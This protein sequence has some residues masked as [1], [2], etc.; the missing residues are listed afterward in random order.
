MASYRALVEWA[1]AAG[2]DV[3]VE[4]ITFPTGDTARI[5]FKTFSARWRVFAGDVRTWR[6]VSTGAA[7]L[8]VVTEHP[9][10]STLQEPWAELRLCGRAGEIIPLLASLAAEH[11]AWSK[12]AYS[13][14]DFMNPSL[15]VRDLLEGGHGVLATGPRALVDRLRA[16]LA[17]FEVPSMVAPPLPLEPRRGGLLLLA[18][19]KSWVVASDLRAEPVGPKDK[20]PFD[21]ATSDD[22]VAMLGALH[23]RGRLPELAQNLAVKLSFFP[24]MAEA[25]ER[26]ENHREGMNCNGPAVRSVSFLLSS[27]RRAL[28]DAPIEVQALVAPRLADAIRGVVRDPSV[29]S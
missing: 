19:G 14:A 23:Q 11:A 10:L 16:V 8:D 6:L 17:R 5:T 3:E 9:V 1:R 27:L 7:P 28:R 24:P 29:L 22:P 21:Y 15:R 20:E 4:R 2:R 13:F 26:I 25:R 18:F 12:G